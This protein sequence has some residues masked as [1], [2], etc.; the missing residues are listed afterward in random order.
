[1]VLFTLNYRE[2]Y[3]SAYAIKNFSRLPPDIVRFIEGVKYNRRF[4]PITD[5]SGEEETKVRP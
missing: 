2:K 5:A 1:M 3:V 4:S